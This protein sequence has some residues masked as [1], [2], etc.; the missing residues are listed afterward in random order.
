M[1]GSSEEMNLVSRGIFDRADLSFFVYLELP[2]S[3]ES[4][5]SV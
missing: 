4:F 5:L 3:T 2:L 1:N